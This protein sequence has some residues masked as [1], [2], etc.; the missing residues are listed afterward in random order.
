VDTL[1]RVVTQR[2]IVRGHRC[3]DTG[4]PIPYLAQ[5]VDDS[6]ADL[7]DYRRSVDKC[8]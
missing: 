8:A 4:L 1:G 6:V 3:V 7:L 2:I 5:L